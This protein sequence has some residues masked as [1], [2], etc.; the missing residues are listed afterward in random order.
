MPSLPIRTWGLAVVLAGVVA[1]SG[2]A[3]DAYVA[4]AADATGVDA[5][6]TPDAA[7]DAVADTPDADI[8][9]D[10][11][12]TPDT[13]IPEPK[14]ALAFQAPAPGTF[15]TDCAAPLPV[16]VAL[17]PAEAA[18]LVTLEG[19][20]VTPVD[21]VVRGEVIPA[22][23][24]NV[25]TAVAMDAGGG[26]SREH[27]AFLC[28]TYA[29]PEQLVQNAADLYLGRA[30]L[31]ALVSVS[32][33][34]FDG[35]D[36]GAGFT[37]APVY[38]NDVVR[39]DLQRI[40]HAP[41]TVFELAPD[42]GTLALELDLFGVD[43]YFTVTIQ[44][45]SGHS[46][47][48]HVHAERL[49]AWA[50]VTLGLGADGAIQVFLDRITFD[51]EGLELYLGDEGSDLLAILPSARDVLVDLL[52]SMLAQ[53]LQDMLPAAL[54]KGLARLSEPFD[55]SLLGRTFQLSFA[56]AALEVKPEGVHLALDLG[57]AGLDPDPSYASPGVLWTPGNDAWAKGL[58]GFRLAVKDDLLNVVF[59]EA[60][61]AGLLQVA[62]DQA[63]IDRNKLEIDLVAGFL[64]GLLERIPD[65]PGPETP[66]HLDLR[67]AFPPVASLDLPAAGGVRLGVGDLRIDVWADEWSWL[68][69]LVPFT[70]TLRAELGVTAEGTKLAPSIGTFEVLLDVASDDPALFAA[71]TYA[72]PVADQLFGVVGPLLGDLLTEIPVPVPEGLVVKSLSVGSNPEN[73]G[74]LLIDG[75]VAKAP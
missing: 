70:L 29:A 63:L 73:G 4:D 53:T 26:K 19:Q 15:V 12:Y 5:P 45:S 39:V 33:D 31:A 59:H 74:T 3:S 66:I 50:T 10:A 44:G 20:L 60:W 25:L 64:G 2:G 21:G 6:G 72:G 27:R 55:V 69:P 71:E 7:S 9:P 48:A 51:F 36:L 24:L 22:E 18:T 32:A 67:P 40:E 42:E 14:V 43:G 54:Q 11:P 58:T 17:T 47:D 52:E 46:Y 61:R 56:P 65:A 34:V 62:I 28:G 8:R 35:L 37:G 1:C 57:L 75:E 23:G 41:G 13:A 30:A 38:E 49:S 16:A 68:T